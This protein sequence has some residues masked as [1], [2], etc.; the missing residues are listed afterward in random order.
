MSIWRRHRQSKNLPPPEVETLTVF[1]RYCWVLE[2]FS[3]GSFGIFIVSFQRR[4]GRFSFERWE[5]DWS[6]LW[7]LFLPRRRRCQII[8]YLCP[9]CTGVCVVYVWTRMYIGTSE[10]MY[11][12]TYVCI[13]CW[14]LKISSLKWSVM[15]I[16]LFDLQKVERAH[17]SQQGH[18][19]TEVSVI[20]SPS[21]LFT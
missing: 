18:F 5:L 9:W 15:S 21:F 6:N 7:Y 13:Y 10:R 12:R 19:S 17:F 1:L 11:V 8:C 4:W 14:G 2:L 16:K 3:S 20:A